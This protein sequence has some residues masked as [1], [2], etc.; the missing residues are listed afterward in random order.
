MSDRDLER[1]ADLFAR[2][3]GVSGHERQIAHVREALESTRHR[4]PERHRRLGVRT[5]NGRQQRRRETHARIVGVDPVPRE[6]RQPNR[7]NARRGA[8]R[9]GERRDVADNQSGAQFAQ[10]AGL[11]GRSRH[12]VAVKRL[13]A[14]NGI[15]LVERERIDLHDA[16]VAF[17][18]A[19]GDL[20]LDGEIE[21][22]AWS[23]GADTDSCFRPLGQDRVDDLDRARGVTESVTGNVE[24]DRL[25]QCGRALTR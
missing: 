16:G 18:R 22:P 11:A 3:R 2:A 14:A 19:E 6:V 20:P 25:C 24:D 21:E 23:R 7:R 12:H 10:R 5:A 15:G 9:E 1:L 8:D 17:E 4:Q 13:R